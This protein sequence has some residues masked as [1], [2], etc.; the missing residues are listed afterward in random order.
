MS[1]S[2]CLES[3]EQSLNKKPN[4]LQE[5]TSQPLVEATNILV[6]KSTF[7]LAD[8]KRAQGSL[9]ESLG[10][11]NSSNKSPRTTKSIQAMP[12]PFLLRN[13][14]P[15]A[16]QTLTYSQVA[17]EMMNT[18]T[19]RQ[20]LENFNFEFLPTLFLEGGQ[21]KATLLKSPKKQLSF[22]APMLLSR[23]DETFAK[24]KI[25]ISKNLSDLKNA[26]MFYYST[27]NIH[28]HTHYYE[29]LENLNNA[30]TYKE[31]LKSID[32]IQLIDQNTDDFHFEQ[33]PFFQGH[34][35]DAE[36]PVVAQAIF[37]H[38]YNFY[39]HVRN[40]QINAD[41]DE[42][43]AY[44]Q[45]LARAEDQKPLMRYIGCRVVLLVQS[46][47]KRTIEA[48]DLRFLVTTRGVSFSLI[49]KIVLGATEFVNDLS[50]EDEFEAVDFE[51]TKA[52]QAA[53]GHFK[54]LNPHD[55]G[56]QPAEA[57]APKYRHVTQPLVEMTQRYLEKVTREF[58]LIAP[59]MGDSEAAFAQL[60]PNA[61]FK[62]GELLEQHS[63]KPCLDQ[64]LAKLHA[65]YAKKIMNGDN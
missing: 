3:S 13:S 58:D 49:H 28:F 34:L 55:H 21:F 61:K 22:Q 7:K 26:F 50:D 23:Y 17:F 12:V 19:Y 39:K 11:R 53:Y 63:K 33:I 36:N 24:M 65:E 37:Y 54:K 59:E 42:E 16:F 27:R 8:K 43:T 1:V 44:I 35:A 9:L 40:I 45:K 6:K 51:R 5:R 10:P 14:T 30:I 64:Q 25:L 52:S 38:K 56:Y 20:M 31:S 2:F 15:F 57:E 4:L 29:F 60:F 46:V 48:C 47:F 18:R 62:L 41:Y 32:C